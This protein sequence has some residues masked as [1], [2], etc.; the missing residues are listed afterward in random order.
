VVF[1]IFVTAPSIQNI[2]CVNVLK[3]LCNTSVFELPKYE[4]FRG[5]LI[6][7]NSFPV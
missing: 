7:I 4:I 6:Q 5:Y 1:K 2:G 3:L